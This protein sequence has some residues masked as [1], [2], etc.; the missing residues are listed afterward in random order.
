MP[1]RS[2]RLSQNNIVSLN[3]FFPIARYDSWFFLLISLLLGCSLNPVVGQENQWIAAEKLIEIPDPI[4][5]AGPFC[6]LVN[7][8]LVVAGGANFP[9]GM[10]WEIETKKGTKIWHDDVYLLERPDGNWKHV[11]KLPRSLGYGVAITLPEGVLLIGGSDASQHYADVYLLT[12]KSDQLQFQSLSAL[13][14]RLANMAGMLIDDKIYVVGG[15][16]TPGEQAA[17]NR[18]FSVVVRELLG[19]QQAAVWSEESPLPGNGRLLPGI[20]AMGSDLFVFGGAEIV[21]EADQR[22]RHYLQNGFKLSLK[23]AQQ[24]SSKHQQARDQVNRSVWQPIADLPVPLVA[25]PFPSPAIG[26]NHFLVC[27]GDDGSRVGFE[28]IDQHPGFNGTCWGYHVITNTWME[29]GSLQKPTVTT[30]IVP[31]QD[32]FVIPSG[33]VRPG[34]RS[35]SVTSLRLVSPTPS[36][37]IINYVSLVVYLLI[38]FGIGLL[39]AGKIVNTNQFFRADQSIP[40]WAAG[41]SIFATMLS[42]ITF[43]SIP[44]QGFSIGWNL[45]VGSIY[46]I[47]T[48]LVA[49]VYVPYF[50]KLDITSAYEFLEIRF[51][52]AVRLFASLQFIL[53]QLGRIAVVLFLPSLALATVAGVNIYVSIVLVGVLCMAYTMLGGMKAVIWTDAVQAVILLGGA[54]IALIAIIDRVPGGVGQI[55]SVADEGQKFFHSLSW[56]WDTTIATGWAIMFGSIFS[57][58]FSYT[59]S[60]DVVQRYLTTSDQKM[61][62]RAIWVNAIMAPLAQALFFAI[63]TG[64]F[65][66]YYYHP[67]KLHPAIANDGIFPFFVVQELPVGLA[68]LIVAAVF[69]ASQSTVSSSLNSLATAVVTDFYRRFQPQ[70]SDRRALSLARFVTLIAGLI[71]IGLAIVLASLGEIRSLWEIFIAV[72]SLFGGSV[73][74]LFFMGMFTTKTHGT[75]AMVGAL[76]SVAVV[77]WMFFSGGLFWWYSVAGVFVCVFVGYTV[78]LLTPQ[79]TANKNF[80]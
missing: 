73:S 63:G 3:Q 12:Y 76:A 13:P 29:M 79:F 58:L 48:P 43:M 31:W 67:H 20:A 80:R 16:H 25:T 37:G 10:P 62:G 55:I 52:L 77:M 5:L 34:V 60:Q 56:S 18:V 65:A 14:V 46:V 47:L 6:G 75:G 42:S 57:N 71:G 11:G 39:A 32:H 45:F 27:G 30:Q 54:L 1:S 74:G 69:A 49:Y 24:Q 72:L 22:R 70:A 36:F 15:S 66:F 4:G 23:Q 17:S 59:A 2:L 28:P 53:F 61:A 26:P 8:S 9:D 35:A 51:N 50:R 21:S 38:V 33:E 64:L 7:D 41:L 40:W 78:S 68:G 19:N 44:A